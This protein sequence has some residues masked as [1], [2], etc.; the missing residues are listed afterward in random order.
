MQSPTIQLDI[1]LA[2]ALTIAVYTD[3]V[4]GKIYNKLTI[5]AAMAGIVVNTVLWGTDGLKTS[6]LGFAL[7][8]GVFVIIA[9]FRLMAGG[10]G[11][12]L[13]VVGCFKGWEFLLY[14]LAVMAIAGGIMAIGFLLYRRL[15]KATVTDIGSRTFARAVLG[16][17]IEYMP[18]LRAGKLPYSVAIA[19]GVVG[20][21]LLGAG[22]P[23]IGA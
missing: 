14:T 5:P 20:A 21:F 15:L 7:G 6:L 18:T 23:P 4:R 10:D 19:A 16:A 9:I 1:I 22:V 8:A 3:I 2:V 12:L 11:K 17:P 13:I